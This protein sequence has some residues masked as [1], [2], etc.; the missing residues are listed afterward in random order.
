MN[1]ISSDT[2][3]LIYMQNYI[4]QNIVFGK[5]SLVLKL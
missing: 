1:S 2:I 4:L 5:D 3:T